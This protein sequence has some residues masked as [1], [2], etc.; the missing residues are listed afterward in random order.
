MVV[1]IVTKLL[2]D[3]YNRQSRFSN[4]NLIEYQPNVKGHHYAKRQTYLY[5]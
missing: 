5:C 3:H 4:L 2:Y 1:T